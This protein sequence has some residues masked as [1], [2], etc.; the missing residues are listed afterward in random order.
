MNLRRKKRRENIEEREAFLINSGL[1]ATVI[2]DKLE[3]NHQNDLIV[4]V[5]DIL[6]DKEEELIG[7]HLT[8]AMFTMNL[9]DY[10]NTAKQ[11]KEHSVLK[12]K[13]FK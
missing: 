4:Q 10:E 11:F 2:I 6:V 7:G 12:V 8:K 13:K 1:A 5:V 3:L 9:D